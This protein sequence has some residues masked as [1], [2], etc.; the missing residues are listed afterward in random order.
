MLAVAVYNTVSVDNC[1]IH[2]HFN[3]ATKGNYAPANGSM[4]KQLAQKFKVREELRCCV[5]ESAAA[6]CP[7]GSELRCC[8]IESAAAFCPV[9][10]G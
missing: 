4:T 3:E 8:A 2:I 9:G 6:F 10:S 7:V 5:I 1:H